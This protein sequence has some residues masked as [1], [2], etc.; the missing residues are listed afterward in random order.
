MNFEQLARTSVNYYLK[1][2]HGALKLEVSSL[3]VDTL[4]LGFIGFSDL[5]LQQESNQISLSGLDLQ[6]DRTKPYWLSRVVLEKG[7]VTLD[8]DSL[9]QW[10]PTKEQ[11]SDT[12]SLAF[13][14]Q[15]LS[16]F[17]RLPE[18]TVKALNADLSSGR[19]GTADKFSLND[20]HLALAAN[21]GIKI[22]LRENRQDLLDLQASFQPESVTGEL[23]GDLGRLNLLIKRYFEQPLMLNGK[24]SSDVTLTPTAA[25][26]SLA[27]SNKLTDSLLDLSE[28]TGEAASFLLDGDFSLNYRDAVFEVKASHEPGLSIEP[29]AD[30]VEILKSKLKQNQLNKD[31]EHF[32]LANIPQQVLLAPGSVIFLNS[33]KQQLSGN[34]HVLSQIPNGELVIRVPAFDISAQQQQVDWQLNYRQQQPFK[35]LGKA[36][37]SLRGEITHS[38][39]ETRLLL[40][41]ADLLLTEIRHQDQVLQQGSFHLTAPALLRFSDNR[42]QLSEKLPF[43]SLFEQ[44]RIQGQGFEQIRAEHEL[45]QAAGAFRLDSRWQLDDAF[46]LISE[47]LFDN[48]TVTGKAMLDGMPLSAVLDRIDLPELL[49]LDAKIS[50]EI[51]Y[52]FK[53]DSQTLTARLSG[54]LVDGFGSYD[55]IAFD[56]I[57]GRWSCSWELPQLSCDQ[58]GF[59]SGH[60]NAGIDITEVSA[61]GKF[62]WQQ[63][64]WSYQ[65]GR[66]S[67]G[68]LD[69]TVALAP[70]DI[71]AGQAFSGTLTLAHIS[72]A[73]LV[74]LQQQPGIEVTGY[75]DGELPFTYD[76]KGLSIEQGTLTNQGEG[77]IK[78]DGNPAVEQLKQSQP[79]LKLALD[80]LKELH[81]QHL[82]S[83]VTM[84]ANGATEIKMS[85]Q[86]RNPENIRPIHFN[87]LHQENLL[88]LL[89]SLR[90]DSQLSEDIEK[91]LNK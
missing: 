48:K 29:T 73:E 52:V 78:V 77:I 10:F 14:R 41:H 84:S 79:E 83:E 18:I 55:D 32:L 66:F 89:R 49:T 4:E 25:G 17:Y 59:S 64:N 34:I 23:T 9:L 37:L 56:D 80:A 7:Q 91:A 45:Q 20:S 61:D 15:L 36:G 62:S 60:V 5:T 50:N 35:Q 12:D 65:L 54:Q 1:H 75:L 19:K 16:A 68:L 67:A 33:E 53:P 27:A 69:G 2:Y 28:V 87:Y 71:L 47:H 72:L 58:L 11:S 82:D 63:G 76:D 39:M 24:L 46:T 6:L 38:D 90:I 26:W 85:M 42:L 51:N 13:Y 30:T 43:T 81:Y 31:I 74:A 22:N 88:Q 44:V 8:I 86:G 70:V 57:K 21:T 3:E 40:N